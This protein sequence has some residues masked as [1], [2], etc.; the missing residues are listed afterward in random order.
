VEDSREN[1]GKT[2]EE[3]K[4]RCR[5]KGK[6]TIARRAE[7][8]RLNRARREK[9]NIFSRREEG[10]G[11]GKR[12]GREGVAVRR[13]GGSAGL[14]VFSSQKRKVEGGGDSSTEGFCCTNTKTFVLV[15]RRKN[16]I[17]LGEGRQQ[18][19]DESSL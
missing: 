13:R 9:G 6:R 1:F 3:K 10:D 8:S 14:R 12:G 5:T 11:S 18:K 15:S 19:K 2:G 7:P 17:F 4:K 16:L